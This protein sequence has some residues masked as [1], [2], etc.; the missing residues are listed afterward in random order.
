MSWQKKLFCQTEE[1]GSKLAKH[2]M[3]KLE[4]LRAPSSRNG[5]DW[6]PVKHLRLQGG[7]LRIEDEYLGSC[8]TL[9]DGL[10]L[11]VVHS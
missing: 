2:V 8:S 1:D 5:Q 3:F 7:D 6:P 9:L 11:G 10:L 4:R